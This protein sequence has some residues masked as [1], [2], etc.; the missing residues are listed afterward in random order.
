MPR[1]IVSDRDS[2][3]LSSFWQGLFSIH[4]TKFLLSSAYHPATDGQTEVVNWCLETYLRC[5]C[6]NHEKDWSFW[7][8]LAEWWYNTHFHTSIQLTPYEIVYGQSPPLHLPYLAGEVA[9]A[10]VDRSLQRRETVFQEIK[11]HLI[12]AQSRMKSQ[13]DQHR[14][15]RSFQIGDWVW[16]KL[17]PYRKQSVQVRHKSLLQSFMD[18]FR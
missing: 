17:Q 2:V 15:D 3:F 10:E 1:S 5:M 18:L 7:I 11:Q 9:N 8:P 14:S 16:L 6:S 12:K 13:A 4:G